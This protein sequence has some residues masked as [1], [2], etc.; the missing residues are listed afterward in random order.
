MGW[1]GGGVVGRWCWSVAVA[2]RLRAS[3]VIRPASVHWCA[4]RVLPRHLVAPNRKLLVD[5]GA[6]PK[7]TR[8]SGRRT[9]GCTSISGALDVP[10]SVRHRDRRVGFR[11]APGSTCRLRFDA[12]HGAP[13]AVRRQTLRPR[14][15]RCRA[16]S[17]RSACVVHRHG[18]GPAE[19][20]DVLDRRFAL[21][22]DRTVTRTSGGAAISAE[23]AG[24][25]VRR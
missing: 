22:P 9:D 6:E 4:A 8:R 25:S 17:P 10:L 5:L 3:A 15:V 7:A 19:P 14:A 18:V 24:T 11:S 12:R 1:V 2:G 13:G 20:P 23:R 16:A 21:G